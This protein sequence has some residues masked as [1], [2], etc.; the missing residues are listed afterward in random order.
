M[1]KRTG[2]QAGEVGQG[3]HLAEQVNDLG[4]LPINHQHEST[5]QEGQWDHIL[6]GAIE[7]GSDG[8]KRW[9]AETARRPCPVRV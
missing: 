7:G 6:F 2:G 4:L 1:E 9:M 5:F 8:E 3:A